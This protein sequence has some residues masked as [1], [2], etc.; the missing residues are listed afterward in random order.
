MIYTT[1]AIESIQA[2]LRKV[3]RNRGAFPSPEAVRKILYLAIE[4]IS[5]KWKRPI[6]DWVAALNHFSA[7][8]EGRVPE[9]E[10]SRLHRK[11]DSLAAQA[12]LQNKRSSKDWQYFK[13]LLNLETD[14]RESCD[15]ADRDAHDLL[16]ELLKV[17]SKHPTA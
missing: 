6:K 17:L 3:A 16:I 10:M 5:K 9:W 8:F 4:R 13:N 2:Q 1:N 11:L 15:E 7:V 12:L 14:L